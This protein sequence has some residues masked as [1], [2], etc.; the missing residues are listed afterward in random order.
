MSWKKKKNSLACSGHHDPLEECSRRFD[1]G[2]S[3]E[4]EDVKEL[5]IPWQG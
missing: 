5:L 3:E 1:A 4:E 2:E